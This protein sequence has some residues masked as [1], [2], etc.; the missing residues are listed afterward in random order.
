MNRNS[1]ENLKNL[2]AQISS[3]IIES[4]G[5]DTFSEIPFKHCVL[6]NIISESYAQEA[7][8]SFPQLNDP[9]WVKTND[10]QIEVKYRTDF[11]SEFDV[12]EGLIGLIRVFNSA[13]ILRAISQLFSIPKL[14]PDPY[15]TGGG[16][17]I[18]EKGGLLDVHVDGNY[19]D[20][21][22]LNRRINVIYY[23]NPGWTEG[24][25][26]EFGLYSDDGKTLMKKVAPLHNRLVIFD[27]HDKSFHG[28]PEPLN[29]PD[30]SN[31][32][33]VILYY[34][35]KDDRP[36]NHNVYKEPHSA[37]WVKKNV[38]DKQGKTSRDFK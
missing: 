15:F 37:L 4:A 12:P 20:A 22:G 13:P 24:M 9:I 38:T 34:Y 7:L 23:L 10:E 2:A 17:N 30:G 27:T 18:T 3:R 35:T 31:R 33:S 25:G 21:S 16:L 26:G 11:Q 32:K 29:F 28:L 14:M 19:H 1:Q 5:T 36:G 8:L 6:D